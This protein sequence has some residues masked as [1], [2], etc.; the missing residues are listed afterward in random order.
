[1]STFSPTSI[2]GCSLWLDASDSAFVTLNPSTTEV[3]QWKDKSGNNLVG[4]AVNKPSY[5]TGSNN[6]KTISFNGSTQYINFGN[7]LNI[8]NSGGIS[9]FAVANFTSANNGTIVAKSIY[10]VAPSRY[11]ILRLNGSDFGG[12]GLLLVSSSSVG[13]SALITNDTTTGNRLLNGNWDRTTSTFY[14]NTGLGAS[15]SL[16]D[17]SG[18]VTNSNSFFVGAYNNSTG[19]A[20]QDALYFQGTISEIIVYLKPLTITERQKV[21]GYLSGK[22]GTTIPS[23]HPYTVPGAPTLA[24]PTAGNGKVNLSWTAPSG[25]AVVESYLVSAT[26]KPDVSVTGTTYEYQ[27]LTNGTTYTFTV[28]AVNAGGVSSASPEKTATPA[29]TVPGAPTLNSAIASNAQVLLSWTAPSDNGG[30]AITSYIIS[31]TGKT[32]QTVS[33][34]SGTVYAFGGLANGTDYT[35]TI[36]AVNA[37]GTSVL[38]SSPVIRTPVFTSACIPTNVTP[39][40][41]WFDAADAATLFRD[42][43]AA[44]AVTASGQTV[45]RWDDKSGNTRNATT[46]SGSVTLSSTR[47]NNRN[48]VLFSDKCALNVPTFVKQSQTSIFVVARG[49]GSSASSY[50]YWFFNTFPNGP[51]ATNQMF[52]SYLFPTGTFAN[53]YY[54]G[55]AV[56]GNERNYG[57]GSTA[58]NP[59]LGNASMVS[60][61]GNSGGWLNGKQLSVYTTI[62]AGDPSNGSL[63]TSQTGRLGGMGEW[64][65]DT[66]SYEMGEIVVVDGIPTND[67]REQIEAYLSAKWGLRSTL[68]TNHAFYLAP[69]TGLTVTAVNSQGIDLVWT[70]SPSIEVT[71]YDVFNGSTLL[72]SVSSGTSTTLTNL[73]NG[74]TYTLT[75]KSYDGTAY[76]TDSQSAIATPVSVPGAPNLT[77]ATAGNKKATLTWTAPTDNGGSAIIGYKMYQVVNGVEVN[78]LSATGMTTSDYPNLT[79]GQSYTFIVKAVNSVGEGASSASKT[80]TPLNT[81]ATATIT[82]SGNLVQNST[83]SASVVV[84]DPD[85]V[86]PISYQWYAGTETYH[87]S[88]SGATS[89]SLYLTQAYVDKWLRLEVTHTDLD[90]SVNMFMKVVGPVANVN[91]TPTGS[92]SISGQ[93]VQGQTLSINTSTLAD[94]DGIPANSFRYQWFLVTRNP[95]TQ[96]FETQFVKLS[97]ESTLTLTQ[98]HVDKYISASVTYDDGQ[99]FTE[100]I[101]L[102]SPVGPVENENDP[103]TG[104]IS[105]SGDLIQGKTLSINTSTLADQDGIPANSFSYEWF[106]VT[107]NP[108]TKQFISTDPTLTLT[109][110]HVGRYISASVSYV[111][112]QGFVETVNL[113]SPV[114][115]IENVNDNPTGTIAIVYDNSQPLQQ[116]PPSQGQTL[117]IDTSGLSDLDGLGTFSYQWS[118][119]T[120]SNGPYTLLGELA[121]LN[122]N[123]TLTQEHVGKFIN[124]TVSYIDGGGVKETVFYVGKVGPIGN[125][126]DLPTGSLSIVGIAK[127]G[128]TLSVDTSAIADLDGLGDFSYNWLMGTNF[129]GPFTTTISTGPTVTLASSHAN[130]YII[131]SVSY[132]DGQGTSEVVTLDLPV[133]PVIGLPKTSSI[134]KATLFARETLGKDILSSKLAIG[135]R[136]PR[137]S[138]AI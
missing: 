123:L 41:L 49:V 63:N 28:K 74:T 40:M 111:D 39:C 121:P 72:K 76:S 13:G 97:T 26:G 113:T 108:L 106:L 66:R 133:G 14:V 77:S 35:F 54:L 33:A 73:T 127:E 120:D 92:I 118:V 75:V 86:G 138:K 99:G 12:L 79:N 91:D 42:T 110:D 112:N 116:S 89:S 55:A 98:E 103:P 68:P 6:L 3:T 24:T 119:A 122:R 95:L 70:A 37:A 105:I 129:G 45:A 15:N 52:F 90:G 29:V 44:T 93:A 48:T 32:D 128:N 4:S 18:N 78:G 85:G 5:I 64:R 16:Q 58:V 22:W 53:T 10:G 21:E 59:L 126:N 107:L 27:G 9:I 20:S 25:T 102:T 115:P 11:S 36:K 38:S 2:S 124:A 125:V 56:V 104:S 61:F 31:A 30:S 80:A 7:V 81:A 82:L 114:G 132:V 8:G 88:I 134:E 51:S 23:N 130:N 1:M 94:Q 62:N 19:T 131:V 96:E 87:T 57:A 34:S 137:N 101:N 100:V 17:A 117:S 71:R 47:I 135:S 65:S 46:G 69:P 84:T 83:V 136:K 109:Q 67:Q 50:G 60:I 43:G